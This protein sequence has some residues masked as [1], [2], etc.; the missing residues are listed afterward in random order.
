M[1]F[2]FRMSPFHFQLKLG[3]GSSFAVMNFETW[4]FV[5]AMRSY[6]NVSEKVGLGTEIS[7]L[8]LTFDS[9]GSIQSSLTSLVT[10]TIL[11]V[12][13]NYYSILNFT[14]KHCFAL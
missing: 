5:L 12:I 14:Y 4:K 3:R 1:G 2:F 11:V 13:Q 6:A 8:I 7:F 9:I 10:P